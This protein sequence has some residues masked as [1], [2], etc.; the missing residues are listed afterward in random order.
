MPKVLIAGASGLV[1]N[2]AM[3]HFASMG[4]PVVGLSRRPVL[5]PG[6]TSVQLDLL[7]AEAFRREL[8]KHSDVTHVIYAA[9]QEAPGLFAG[10][11]AP[12][13]IE[14]NA[15][16]LRN[17]FDPLL[18]AAPIEHVSLL[19]G[20]KAYGIHHPA[21]GAAGIRV[22]LRER[23]PRVEH[24][25]FY[26]EQEDY[27]HDQQARHPFALTVFRP[28]VIYGGAWGNNMN[29]L[30]VIA[31][32]ASLL[33]ERGEPLHFPGRSTEPAVREAVDA[34]L[35]AAALGWAANS[36][37]AHEE[38]FNLTNGD[39]FDWHTVWPALAEEL[40]MEAGEHRPFSF[41]SELP[42]RQAEWA[43]LVA[44]HG[45]QAPADILQ[46]VGE[47]SLVYTDMLFAG[48]RPGPPILNSTVKARQAGFHD[49]IDTED[50]FRK[51]LRKL[52]AEGVIP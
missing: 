42:A 20:T 32:Y 47:N 39:V 3:H 16:M 29:P 43:G 8:A 52:R 27:L 34:D 36:P 49:C 33:R 15:M 38:T 30:P 18:G 44:R 9:L 14:R 48:P 28:T 23:E 41:A 21:V 46:F 50:M 1:G 7:D 5:V 17:L 31:A 19:H 11:I 2:A 35:V 6:A 37:A 45:L 25:N 4:W 10:W 26:F 12:E 51:W 22:P 40:E 13:L 24:P